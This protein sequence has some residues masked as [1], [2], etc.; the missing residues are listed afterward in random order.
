LC[1]THIDNFRIVRLPALDQDPRFVLLVPHL[2]AVIGARSHHARA[3]VVEIDC[4]H[5][6]LVA[7][8][9]GLE[10]ALCRHFRIRVTRFDKVRFEVFHDARVNA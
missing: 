8:G 9:E 6:I 3:K 7:M 5:K 1:Y 2:E 4:K 10:A